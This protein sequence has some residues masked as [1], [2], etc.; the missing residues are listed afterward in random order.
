MKV[1]GTSAKP[2]PYVKITMSD[3]VFVSSIHTGDPGANDRF[4]ETVTLNFAKVKFEYTPQ[5]ADG[6]PDASVDTGDLNIAK[7]F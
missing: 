2:I 7:K 5:K 1:S 6:S 3:T 4:V